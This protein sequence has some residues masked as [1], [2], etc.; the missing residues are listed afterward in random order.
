MTEDYWAKTSGK[1]IKMIPQ[2]ITSYVD[3]VH[4][5]RDKN[6]L[7]NGESLHISS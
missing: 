5:S 4:D 3:S 7:H 2:N 6:I 1:T